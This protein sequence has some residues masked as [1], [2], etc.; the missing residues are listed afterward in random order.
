MSEQ[1]ITIED[2]DITL[3][4]SKKAKSINIT[5]RPFKGV[6]VSVP[7]FVSYD[8]AKSAGANTAARG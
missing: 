4:R 3:F 5:I 6:R 8:K 1:V 7:S 2:I